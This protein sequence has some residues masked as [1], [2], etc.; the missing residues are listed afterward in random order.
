MEK[1]IVTAA[2]ILLALCMLAVLVRLIK[3]PRVTDR[4][5]AVNALTTLITGEICL[6]SRYLQ[7]DY[8]IDVALIYALLGFVVN[9]L[10][11]RTLSGMKKKEAEK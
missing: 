7:V 6:L 3:G 9:T 4:I 5:L 10:L 1:T 11:T 2:M 8:L